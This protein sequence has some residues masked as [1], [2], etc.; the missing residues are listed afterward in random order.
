MCRRGENVDVE[1]V[2]VMVRRGGDFATGLH[3]KHL[4]IDQCISELVRALNASGHPTTTACCGHGDAPGVIG[5]LDGRALVVVDA[6]DR[7][8]G[9]I[10]HDLAEALSR[11]DDAESQRG[12]LAEEVSNLRTAIHHGEMFDREV[13]AEHHAE[14]ERLEKSNEDLRAEILSLREERKR[15]L[16]QIQNSREETDL[17]AGNARDA[18][19]MLAAIADHHGGEVRIPR[20][21]IR[22]ADPNALHVR[23]TP[24]GEMF[25]TTPQE[26]HGETT[27]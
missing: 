16:G 14:V 23:S 6:G 15:L 12:D 3:W 13:A 4:P 24:H 1:M 11:A 27:D 9:N 7:P 10:A 5:L 17:L 22:S 26:K 25:L 18:T 21:V 2:P 20:N 8:L 19:V